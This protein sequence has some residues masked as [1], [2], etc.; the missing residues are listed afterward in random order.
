MCSGAALAK[1]YVEENIELLKKG[2]C[3]LERHIQNSGMFGVPVVVGVNQ[4]ATDTQAELDA[5][6][7]AAIDAGTLPNPLPPK[8]SAVW[9]PSTTDM[10]SSI[11]PVLLWNT[12][13]VLCM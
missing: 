5:V 13:G 8:T 2:C 6:K 12:M 3:N 10:L 9:R 4:F 11:V 1:E 7:K